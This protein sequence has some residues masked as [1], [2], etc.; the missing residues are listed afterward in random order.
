MM[1]GNRAGS[2]EDIIVGDENGRIG[3]AEQHSIYRLP[4]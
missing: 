3:K 4:T 2:Y 1:P